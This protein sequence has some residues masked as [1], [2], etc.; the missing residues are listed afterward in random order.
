MNYE[1]LLLQVSVLE[2]STISSPC[3]KAEDQ[4]SIICNPPLSPTPTPT[5]T[6]TPSITP[7]LSITPTNTTTQTNTPTP[8]TTP[9]SPTPT[10][11]NTVTPSIT[12]T[13]TVSPTSTI[14]PTPSFPANILL[15]KAN[16]WT[17]ASNT[18]DVIVKFI[19]I[20]PNYNISFNIM[21][22]PS[23]ITA[24]NNVPSVSNI[25]VNDMNYGQL[26]YDTQLQNKTIYSKINNYTYSGYVTSLN[27]ILN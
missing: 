14:T 2:H 15:N 8:T 6:I 19:P 26:L 5:V 18:N 24:S 4:I 20:D 1:Y 21:L 11:T 13:Q 23:N 3:R 25:V 16:N 22:N 12:P 7:T 10:P 27:T 9:V 17:F